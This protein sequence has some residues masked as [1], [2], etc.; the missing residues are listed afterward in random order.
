MRNKTSEAVI[1]KAQA[2]YVEGCNRCPNPAFKEVDHEPLCKDCALS[3]LID[4]VDRLSTAY[5]IVSAEV[6]YED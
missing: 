1:R 6:R 4:I 5:V 2:D 3:E